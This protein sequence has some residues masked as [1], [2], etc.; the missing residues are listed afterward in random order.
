MAESCVLVRY[1]LCGMSAQSGRGV[2]FGVWVE[3]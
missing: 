3:R 1:D 2:S